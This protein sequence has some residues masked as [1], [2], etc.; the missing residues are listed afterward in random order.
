M[1]KKRFS[2]DHKLCRFCEKIGKP[3]RFHP[4]L[5]CKTRLNPQPGKN[6]TITNKSTNVD[7]NFKVTNNTEIE[8][9]LNQES[10]PRN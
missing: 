10:I 1:I 5:E 9:A 3:G 4:E 7:K 6:Y 8:D 2:P